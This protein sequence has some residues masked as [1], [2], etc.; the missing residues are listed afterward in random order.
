MQD[1]SLSSMSWIQVVKE[2]SGI[3]SAQPGSPVKC[4]TIAQGNRRVKRHGKVRKFFR[5]LKKLL[6]GGGSTIAH[7]QPNRRIHIA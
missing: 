6:P 4:D 5:K 2:C 3:S 1:R 7:A